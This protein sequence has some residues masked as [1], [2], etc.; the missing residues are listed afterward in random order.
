M[1]FFVVE[2]PATLSSLGTELA[3]KFI[4]E[5]KRSSLALLLENLNFSLKKMAI[6]EL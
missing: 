4:Y 2:K 3:T 1:S 5:H 6:E